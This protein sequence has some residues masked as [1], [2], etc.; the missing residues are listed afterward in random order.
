MSLYVYVYGVL[1]I[2]Q[3]IIRLIIDDVNEARTCIISM[4]LRLMRLSPRTIGST[5]SIFI[6]FLFHETHD[7]KSRKNSAIIN[8]ERGKKNDGKKRA[9]GHRRNRRLLEFLAINAIKVAALK[10]TFAYV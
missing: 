1:F 7:H 8:V 9:R 6:C 5:V 10:R 3:N 2:Y 4:T